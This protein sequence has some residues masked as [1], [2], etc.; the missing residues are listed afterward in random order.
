MPSQSAVSAVRLTW[1]SWWWAVAVLFHTLQAW[2]VF[3]GLANPTAVGMWEYVAAGAALVVIV[4][5]A[6][7]PALVPMSVGVVVSAWLA[8]PFIGNHWVVSSLLS[9]AFLAALGYRLAR[10]RVPSGYAL[11]GT[12]LPTAR[13]VFL[14]FYSFSA[15]A[16]INRGF[17]EPLTSC[18]TYFT[19]QTGRS[20]GWQSIDT[21]GS[22][23]FG[24]A[25]AIG[26]IV[27]E[28]S[29]VVLLAG[30]RTRMWGVLLG[31]LFHGV[32]G[33]D[34]THSFADFTALVYAFLVLFVPDRF[35]PWVG[36]VLAGRQAV[37]TTCRYVRGYLL[38]ATALTLVLIIGIDDGGSTYGRVGDVRDGLW[39]LITVV[40][41]V[42]VVGFMVAERRALRAERIVLVP[43]ARWLLL[44]PLLAVVNGVLPY[45]GVKTA[46]SWNMY[47]NLVTAPGYENGLLVPTGWGW[48][49][50]QA[51]LVQ[52]VDSSDPGLR[53]YL[54]ADYLI[55]FEMFRDYTSSRPS[56][57]VVYRRGGELVTVPE[58]GVHPELSRPISVWRR[59]L[60]GLR[61]IDA[62]GPARCQVSFLPAL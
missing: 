31:V 53:R 48:D 57:S 19:D 2:P 23:A 36:Q 35:F 24:R 60:G 62:T 25:M 14:C 30:R 47:S 11:E 56:L 20:L 51:D 21:A 54:D 7:L 5:P 17:L 18:A 33:L 28:L 32:I 50:R 59:K 22:G 61:S 46:Y 16:K 39:R 34:G 43:V 6:W 37:A 8:A 29:V 3:G 58:A 55:P 1:F 49:G 45:A 44:V 10:R 42:A 13:G 4:R 26:V 9:I 27:I 40:V 41:V 52:I 12:F 38:A 15:I